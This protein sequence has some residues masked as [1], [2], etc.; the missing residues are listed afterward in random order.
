[1][2]TY[3]ILQHNFII[4]ILAVG[5]KDLTSTQNILTFQYVYEHFNMFKTYILTFL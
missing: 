4:A 1:M 5:S 3:I 2:Y